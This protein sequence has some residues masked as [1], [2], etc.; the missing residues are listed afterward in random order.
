[1]SAK[2]P[3]ICWQA[4]A[5]EAGIQDLWKEHYPG[6]IFVPEYIWFNVQT[7]N[8]GEENDHFP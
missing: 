3:A 4:L 6:N 8:L 2:G 7:M 5:D 1:M